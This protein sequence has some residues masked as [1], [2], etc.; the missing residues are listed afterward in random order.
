MLGQGQLVGLQFR[1]EG[2]DGGREPPC[3]GPRDSG[4]S[5]VALS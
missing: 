4:G 2:N 1:A 5:A 3:L